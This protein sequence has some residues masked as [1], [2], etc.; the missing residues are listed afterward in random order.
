M[1]CIGR[2]TR[3]AG[4]WVKL[5]VKRGESEIEL[6]LVLAVPEDLGKLSRIRTA[7]SPG[8]PLRTTEPQ[9][10]CATALE[11]WPGPWPFLS[12]IVSPLLCPFDRNT[13]P[14]LAYRTADPR[15]SWSSGDFVIA[16]EAVTKSSELASS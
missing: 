10:G 15:G 11:Q 14:V 1:G 13:Y 2:R 6:E 5:W 7:D 9:A 16:G 3:P 4:E 12:Q 8:R